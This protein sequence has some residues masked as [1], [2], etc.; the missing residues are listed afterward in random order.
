[1]N[2]LKKLKQKRCEKCTYNFIC[3]AINACYR[4]MKYIV[5]D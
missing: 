1:M 2:I 5:N 3:E 4:S